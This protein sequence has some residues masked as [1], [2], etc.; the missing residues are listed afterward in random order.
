MGL[1]LWVTNLICNADAPSTENYP[2][3]MQNHQHLQ[4][5]NYTLG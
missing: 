5:L 3:K 1:G 4:E 2:S